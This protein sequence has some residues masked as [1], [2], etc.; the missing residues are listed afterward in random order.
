MLLAIDMGN[1]NITLAVFDGDTALMEARM[2]T[3][4][5]KMADQYAVDILN[6]L[7]LHKVDPATIDGAILSSVVP[8]LDHALRKAVK[9]I[10]DI[11]PL[12]VGP[13]VK[14]G[15]NIRIDNPAQLGA[16]LLVGAVAAAAKYPT[17][18]IVWDLGTATTVSVIDKD[19]A[20]LGGAILAGVFTAMDALSKQTSLLPR[21]RLE[22]PAHTIGKNT[23]ECMQAGTVFGTAATIDGIS[24]RFEAELGQKATVIATGGLSREI[25][26]YCTHDVVYD[27]HLLMDGLRI[28]YNKNR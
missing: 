3:D 15:I 4:H 17:P 7:Q 19:G 1:T 6:I 20:F 5:N 9:L 12:Q 2:A 25:V 27:E 18:C 28:I 10:T 22:A 24:D 13:G 21:I 8:P 11:T 14:T 16:D 26:S 23:V